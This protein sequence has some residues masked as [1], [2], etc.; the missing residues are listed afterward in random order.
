M[1]PGAL[2]RRSSELAVTD[3]P[4]S[5]SPTRASVSPRSSVKLTPSTA[6]A[7]PARVVNQVC[8]WRTSS[9]GGVAAGGAGKGAACKGAMDMALNASSD[10]D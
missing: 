8:N 1:R 4:L 6:R 10:G 3:L 5:L 9:R 2:P 7:T